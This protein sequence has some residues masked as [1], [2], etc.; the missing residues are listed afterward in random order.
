MRHTSFTSPSP[1]TR[2]PR[3]F[4]LGSSQSAAWLSAAF[5]VIACGCR[6]T[7]APMFGGLNPTGASLSPATGLTPVAPG[8]TP[9]L[10]PLGGTGP[11]GGATRVT[12]PPTGS[13]SSGNSNPGA[14]APTTGYGSP[15]AYAPQS[16][17]SQSFGTSQRFGTQ[18]V[19]NA[20]RLENQFAGPRNQAIGSGVLQTSASGPNDA[21]SN[22]QA[23]WTETGTMLNPITQA[24]A[25]L[26]NAATIRPTA[27]G[28]Q[29]VSQ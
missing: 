15:A 4:L 26:A 5:L 9:V 29:G 12:P 20:G 2:S 17:N 27:T 1:A 21:I 18:G 3:S 13:F 24:A 22:Q 16:F 19:G 14:I 28:S 6:Q 11:F 10:G 23:G 7:T 25:P 8:Q